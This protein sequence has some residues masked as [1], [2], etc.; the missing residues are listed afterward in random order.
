MKHTIGTHP[1]GEITVTARCLDGGCTWTLAPTADLKA[2]DMAMMTHTGLKGHPTFARTFED[3]ALVRR[4]ELNEG[5][6]EIPPLP[7]PD[8]EPQHEH[9]AR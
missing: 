1:R 2:A 4:L 9:A 3:V 5:K 6:R 8:E 7:V